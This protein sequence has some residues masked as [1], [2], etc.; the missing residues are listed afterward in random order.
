MGTDVDL[1]DEVPVTSSVAVEGKR[2]EEVGRG[3]TRIR[4]ATITAPGTRVGP[5]GLAVVLTVWAVVCAVWWW[6]K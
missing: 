5:G 4:K 3:K 1:P 6:F 2:W